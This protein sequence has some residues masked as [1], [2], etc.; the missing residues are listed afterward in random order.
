MVAVISLIILILLLAVGS[1]SEL[2]G[3]VTTIIVLGL[4]YLLIYAIVS[5]FVSN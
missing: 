3:C 4:V 2:S 1:D 5:S